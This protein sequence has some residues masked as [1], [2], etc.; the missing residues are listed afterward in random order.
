MLVLSTVQARAD[1]PVI[2]VRDDVLP[3]GTKQRVLATYLRSQPHAEFVYTSPA[4]G[5]AQVALP[6]AARQE[7]RR[8]TVFVS[9]QRSGRTELT[10]YAASLG[11]KIVEPR[12]VFTMKELRQCAERYVA[13]QN[14]RSPTTEAVVHLPFG[15]EHEAMIAGLADAVGAAL[16]PSLSAQPPGR[17]WLV[18]GS[19]MILR[20]LA[21]LWPQALFLCVQVGKPIYD[22]IVAGIRHEKFIAPERFWEP[23]AGAR[24]PYPSVASYDAKLWRFVVEHAEP[25]DLVWNVA[26]DPE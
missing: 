20:A 1:T 8:A 22:D 9:P 26:R 4:T 14:A 19:G 10:K 12:G 7:Q 23:A 17:V 18:V 2:V 21:R 24:P 25:G 11:A 3:G 6:I 16:P 13:E 5:F 15:L